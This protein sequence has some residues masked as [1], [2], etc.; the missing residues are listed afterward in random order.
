MK[1]DI[2][3]I[4]NIHKPLQPA[5]TEREQQLSTEMWKDSSSSQ[6]KLQPVADLLLEKTD[7]SKGSI[8]FYVCFPI[9]TLKAQLVALPN[10]RLQQSE[11]GSLNCFLSKLKG[12]YYHLFFWV[13]QVLPC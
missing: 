3:C 13:Y 6:H 10:L 7:E 11:L 1:R 4:K 12:F 9:C 8:C 2:R 5:K